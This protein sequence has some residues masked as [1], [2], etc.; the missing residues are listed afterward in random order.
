MEVLT[1]TKTPE[2]PTR[3]GGHRGR[4]HHRVAYH[5]RSGAGRSRRRLRCGHYGREDLVDGRGGGGGRGHRLG[6]RAGIPRGP[7]A[8]RGWLR[9]SRGGR[10]ATGRPGLPLYLSG[11]HLV[12]TPVSGGLRIAGGF[13]PNGP[14]PSGRVPTDRVLRGPRSGPATLRTTRLSRRGLARGPVSQT[15]FRPSDG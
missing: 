12:A 10:A 15:G 14:A 7:P 3:E 6:S 4:R 9:L 13:H 1:Q 5:G 8:D 11:S 2:D